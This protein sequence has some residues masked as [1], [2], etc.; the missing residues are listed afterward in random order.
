[1]QNLVFI[2]NISLKT[3]IPDTRD[4]IVLDDVTGIEMSQITMVGKMALVTN[5]YKRPTHFEYCKEY[6]YQKTTV[7]DLVIDEEGRKMLKEV[8]VEAPAPGTPKDSLYPFL[9]K[10][11]TGC[12]TGWRQTMGKAEPEYGRDRGDCSIH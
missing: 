8:V 5:L 10:S 11:T 6:P 4:G 1:M 3:E 9:G 12:G 7:S 2:E